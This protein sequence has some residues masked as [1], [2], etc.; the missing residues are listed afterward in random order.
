MST[1]LSD[2]IKELRETE[3]RKFSQGFDLIINITNIDMKKPDSRFVK[4]ISLPHG[5]GKEIKVGVISEKSEYDKD[6]LLRMEKDKK[7]AKQFTKSYDFF[8]CEVPLMT[9]VG[10]SLGRYLGPAGKMP[11]PLPP[12]VDPKNMM[13]ALE[14]SVRVKLNTTPVVQCTIG[15]EKM[16]DNQIKENADKVIEEVRKILP[17]KSYIKNV[18]IKK[19]MSKP[20]LLDIK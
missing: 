18:Y 10:K 6:F 20:V 7:A 2:A 19:T 5:K 16:E 15:T 8:L 12:N 1:N 11:K 14:K 3:K 9:L 17:G 13:K 4:E